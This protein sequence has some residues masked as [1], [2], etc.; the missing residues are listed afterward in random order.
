MTK[1]KEW[2]IYFNCSIGIHVMTLD[3]QKIPIKFIIEKRCKHCNKL[4]GLI[5]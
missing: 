2:F 3:K 1:L 5:T 4:L